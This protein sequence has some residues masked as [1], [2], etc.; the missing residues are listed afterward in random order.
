MQQKEL[1]KDLG[2]ADSTLRK[3]R[4]ALNIPAKNSYS[5]EEVAKLGELK[6][7][8]QA[9]ERYEA[10]IADMTG[11]DRTEPN[12]L[13]S[14]LGKH[15]IPAIKQIAEP[16]A[17]NF[18][19]ELDKQVFAFVSKKLRSRGASLEQF[20]VALLTSDGEDP[21]DALLLEGCT[22]EAA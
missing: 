21:I 19:R 15:Y 4:A 13:A 2:I 22:D 14:A 12:G 7:R 1:I 11:Q 18:I 5:E 10:V 9:G 17:E 6:T 8:T 3:W 20:E 16:V